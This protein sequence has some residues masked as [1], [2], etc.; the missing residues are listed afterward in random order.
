MLIE[1]CCWILNWTSRNLQLICFPQWHF[2]LNCVW[3]KPGSSTSVEP[4]YSSS[5]FLF[6]G[7]FLGVTCLSCFSGVCRVIT[8]RTKQSKLTD[9]YKL[10]KGFFIWSLYRLT[11]K[12]KFT[13]MFISSSLWSSTSISLS[14]LDS[15]P[16]IKYLE[17]DKKG[18]N[19][20]CQDD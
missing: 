2:L 17:E 8:A 7:V 4:A 18:V 10:E 5:S 20:M 9:C 19:K 13:F 16:S 14:E 11:L 1:Y 12:N 6:S 3:C 15:A